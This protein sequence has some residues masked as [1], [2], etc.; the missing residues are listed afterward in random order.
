[1]AEDD[2]FDIDIYGDDP[3]PESVTQDQERANDQGQGQGQSQDQ[4]DE[5]HDQ[6]VAPK[7]ESDGNSENEGG[8][9]EMNTPQAPAE[10]T[11]PTPT[12]A[13]A[14]QQGTKRKSSLAELTASPALVLSDLNWWNTDDDIRGWARA[15]SLASAPSPTNYPSAPEESA[16]AHLTEITFSEHKVNGKSK[17]QAFL[18]FSSALAA[19]AVK[20][21][22]EGH[23]GMQ[24]KPSITFQAA[25]MNPF[26]TLPKDAPARQASTAPARGDFRGGY[27]GRGRGGF[28]PRGGGG[29]GVV[30]GGFQGNGGFPM[31]QGGFGMQG[32]GGGFNQFNR[33]GMMPRGGRGGP[34][35][36]MAAMGGMMPGMMG[37]GGMNMGMMPGMMGGFNQGFGA[38]GGFNPG[39]YG[40]NMG[41]GQW[42]NPH[43]AKR[44]RGE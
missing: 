32:M 15:A 40:G 37:M 2:N 14:P 5:S 35:G 18:A 22:I 17:G 43:G 12:A 39:G 11:T 13:Q 16:E 31:Q 20:T 33:G 28:Q 38:A 34:R 1:M 3:P 42:D 8:N 44:A 9:T 7:A 10:T 21:Y 4:M 24:K 19:N 29:T 23:P 26:K 27:R 36:G 6:N 41:Q 25:G 30:T